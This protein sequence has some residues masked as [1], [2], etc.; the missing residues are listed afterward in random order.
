MNVSFYSGCY[1]GSMR[2]TEHKK[3]LKGEIVYIHPKKRFILV[4]YT[5][6]SMFG[7]KKHK[8]RECLKLVN[9]KIFN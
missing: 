3:L 5:V 2:K 4:E 9:G 7:N 6:K 1:S 8:L